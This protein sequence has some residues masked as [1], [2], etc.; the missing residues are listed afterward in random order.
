MLIITF[1]RY[2]N[3]NLNILKISL[4]IENDNLSNSGMFQ[5]SLIN[6]FELQQ[7]KTKYFDDKSFYF[8][9]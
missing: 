3:I 5:V 1:H 9:I 7:K 6:T 4:V 2:L 8:Y